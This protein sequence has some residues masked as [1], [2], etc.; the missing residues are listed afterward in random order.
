V[1]SVGQ[2]IGPGTAVFTQGHDGASGLCVDPDTAAVFETE[3]AQAATADRAATHDEVNLLVRGSDYGWPDPTSS[4][5]GAVATLP[6][7]SGGQPALAA[8]CAISAGVLYVASLDATTLYSA[9]IVSTA[10]ST[11]LDAFTTSLTGIYGRLITVV[12][13]TD[14]SLWLATS[15]SG[16]TPAP[17]GS[18][19][20]DERILHVQ[21]SGGGADSAA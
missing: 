14:G 21:P 6:V 19:P 3:P 16:V 17:Q 8:G 20:A 5:V 2:L 18:S 10:S 11:K 1:N 12:A 9:D 4:S 15:N 13:D 7:R